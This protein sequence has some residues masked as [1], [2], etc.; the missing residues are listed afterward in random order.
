MAHEVLCWAAGGGGGGG[1]RG[2][3]RDGMEVKVG[4]QAGGG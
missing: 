3:W 2:L 1:V 4:I